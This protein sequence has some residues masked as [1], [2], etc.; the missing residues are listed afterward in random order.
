MNVTRALAIFTARLDACEELAQLRHFDV[1]FVHQII[2]VKH[3]HSHAQQRLST[4]QSHHLKKE[5][6][7]K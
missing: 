4:R 5:R 3:R 6:N 1:E 7:G 2:L